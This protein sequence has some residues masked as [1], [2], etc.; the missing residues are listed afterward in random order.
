MKSKIKDKQD[1]TKFCIECGS[2]KVKLTYKGLETDMY[3]YSHCKKEYGV[4][5]LD[6]F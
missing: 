3:Y 5:Y 4:T 1:P 6:R 2:K